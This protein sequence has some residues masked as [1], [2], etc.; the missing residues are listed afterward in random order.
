MG[1]GATGGAMLFCCGL[2]VESQLGWCNYAAITE[3]RASEWCNF[4]TRT[5]ALL[6]KGVCSNLCVWSY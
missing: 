5:H 2:Q 4:L 6:C 3:H 1:G